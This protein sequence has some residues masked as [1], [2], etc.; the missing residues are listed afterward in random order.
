[1]PRLS[2]PSSNAKVQSTSKKAPADTVERKKSNVTEK[3][4]RSEERLQTYIFRVLKRAHPEIGISKTA[5]LTLNSMLLDFYR[6]IAIEAGSASRNK[7]QTLTARDIQ[8]AV[9]LTVKGDLG[10]HTVTC[11][12]NAVQKYQKSTN[13]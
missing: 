2:K 12:T 1:M 10:K 13:S 6:K 7:G 8:L 11:G 4:F 5:M 9:K 3:T